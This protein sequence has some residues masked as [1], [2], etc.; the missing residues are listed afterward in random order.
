MSSSNQS[1]IEYRMTNDTVPESMLLSD[2]IKLDSFSAEIVSCENRGLTFLPELPNC[3]RLY[4]SDN[5]LI[6]L[7]KLDNCAYL[8]CN[9]NELKS[10][11]KLPLCQELE[12]D[13]NRLSSLPSIPYCTFLS[14]SKNMIRKL[15]NIPRCVELNCE[16]NFLNEIKEGYLDSCK[17]LNCNDNRLQSLPDLP[18]CLRL[19]CNDNDLEELPNL[20]LCMY[21]KCVRNAL[22]E[23]PPLPSCLEISCS[24]NYISYIPDLDMCQYILCNNNSLSFLPDLPSCKE[25]SI[26]HNSLEYLPRLPLCE[27]LYC[28]NNNLRVIDIENLPN[29][30]N[31]NAD[32]NP[33][34]YRDYEDW[35]NVKRINRGIRKGM[36]MFKHG[37]PIDI[38]QNI[39]ST[40][41]QGICRHL[42][43]AYGFEQL[44]EFASS[45]EIDVEG[46]SKRE[47]CAELTYS[48]E[49]LLRGESRYPEEAREQ[50]RQERQ[51]NNDST[52]KEEDV[53]DLRDHEILIDEDGNC[54][55]VAELEELIRSN[56][57]LDVP[58][59]NPYTRK[60]L[61]Q[62]KV[63]GTN[64]PFLEE[65]ERR[66]QFVQPN[67]HE[68]K[69]VKVSTEM[70]KLQ[71]AN[72]IN[73][74]ENMYFEPSTFDNLSLNKIACIMDVLKNNP[75]FADFAQGL[76]SS[77]REDDFF[78]I[79]FHLL[80][81]VQ[82]ETPE[83]R[84]TA[85]LIIKQAFRDC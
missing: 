10:L 77:V 64:I 31:L 42:S 3:K 9:N 52:L 22:N 54:F 15:P 34:I 84:V 14:C 40:D 2:F 55:S 47:L 30:R 25:L 13:N 41:W 43:K 16:T 78:N 74:P 6:Q 76:I 35:D 27:T 61:S 38:F 53:Y 68:M 39:S 48:F 5:K 8:Y 85:S 36:N 63:K 57:D 51:C 80:S 72:L 60:P 81:R 44:K 24:T 69:I 73:S 46:K 45:I 12:C 29:I 7:P 11:P 75:V 79:L 33:L 32:N 20:D 65:F 83:L 66:L 50:R 17:N 71:L 28:S 62:I 1:I 59:V 19:D 56:E 23:L 49:A 21:L 82:K 67:I 4:C 26:E 70:K 37:R 58:V 18:S